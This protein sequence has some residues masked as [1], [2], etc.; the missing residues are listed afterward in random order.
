MLLNAPHHLSKTPAGLGFFALVDHAA[1][2]HLYGKVS[3]GINDGRQHNAAS[4]VGWRKDADRGLV[5]PGKQR[6]ID[7]QRQLEAI[8]LSSD[9]LRMRQQEVFDLAQYAIARSRKVAREQV[10]EREVMVPAIEVKVFGDEVPLG[11]LFGASSAVGAVIRDRLL[12]A[13]L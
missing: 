9:A 3:D 6:T 8:F 1:Q 5:W 12:G 7:V 4:E 10:A 2:G 11:Q 13:C